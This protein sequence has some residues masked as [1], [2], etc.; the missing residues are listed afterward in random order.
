[1]ANSINPGYKPSFSNGYRTS[2]S[3]GLAGMGGTSDKRIETP[4][5]YFNGKLYTSANSTGGKESDSHTFNMSEG[6]YTPKVDRNTGDKIHEPH[7]FTTRMNT[8]LGRAET[9]M[10]PYNRA[11]HHMLPGAP[12]G[13]TE[14]HEA[15]RAAN[16]NAGGRNWTE[17]SY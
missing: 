12:Q 16:G 17:Q 9:L 7:V 6:A 5:G 4:S 8:R 14:A 13:D 11:R 10:E 2:D 15:E 3:N 1:M